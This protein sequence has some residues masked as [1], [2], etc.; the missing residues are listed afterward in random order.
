MSTCTAV[1]GIFVT[2]SCLEAAVDGLVSAGLSCNGM[3]LLMS[4]KGGW[5]DFHCGSADKGQ[6]S[7]V[8]GAE[9]GGVV[10]GLV[11]M[12]LGLGALVIP[13]AGPLVAAGPIMASL[14]G[15]SVGGALGGLVS[16]LVDLGLP[17]YEAKLYDG[18]LKNGA[19]LLSVH[20]LSTGQI[21]TA[22]DVLKA[23]G[24]EDIASSGEDEVDAPQLETPAMY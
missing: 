15:L 13:G 18:R 21:D 8:A 23:N 3:S 22:K 20:C 5:H 19:V 4:D 9:V 12:L 14:A 1:Y 11:G 16:A 7:V 24:A 6:S 17:E 2:P 10:G